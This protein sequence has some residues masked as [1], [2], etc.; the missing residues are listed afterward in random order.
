MKSKEKKARTVSVTVILVKDG[1]A[2][3]QAKTAHEVGP[4]QTKQVTARGLT[5]LAAIEALEKEVAQADRR[6]ALKAEY[7]AGGKKIEVDW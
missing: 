5:E 2:V 3:F 7:P 4:G 6:A 1:D